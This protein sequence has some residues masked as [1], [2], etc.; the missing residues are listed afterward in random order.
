[1]AAAEIVVVRHGESRGNVAAAAA[2]AAGAEVIEVGQRD[3]DVPLS[4]VGRRQAEALGAGI[5]ALL[6]DGI[7]TLVWC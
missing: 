3:A 7:P 1:M 5:R 4:D 2:H 6:A